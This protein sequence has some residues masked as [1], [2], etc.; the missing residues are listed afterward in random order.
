MKTTEEIVVK[1]CLETE[2]EI[3][4]EIQFITY[5]G[6]DAILLRSRRDA[7]GIKSAENLEKII[8]QYV[9]EEIIEDLIEFVDG[10]AKWTDAQGGIDCLLSTFTQNQLRGI[11]SN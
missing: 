11:L 9:N 5:L 4:A 3:S 6:Y 8:D 2:T 7:F 10:M 1:Y